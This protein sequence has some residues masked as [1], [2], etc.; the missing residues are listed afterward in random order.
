MTRE[1]VVVHYC[2]DMTARVAAFDEAERATPAGDRWTSF[3]RMLETPLYVGEAPTDDAGQPDGA[4]G[5]GAGAEDRLANDD[6]GDAARDG[7][8]RR[9]KRPAGALALRLTH[10][11]PAGRAAEAARPAFVRVTPLARCAAAPPAATAHPQSS[12]A[13]SSTLAA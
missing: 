7:A 4:A 8:D 11:S 3:S 10:E 12:R 5:A 9:P 1:A 2:D 6:P 13:S